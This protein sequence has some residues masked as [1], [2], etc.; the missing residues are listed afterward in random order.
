MTKATLISRTF[1]WGW[2]MGA[3]VQSIIIQAA[4]VLEKELGIPH[5]VPKANRRK[6][7]SKQVG[8]G[9]QRP[10]PQWHTS[11][12]KATPPNSATLKPSQTLTN[13]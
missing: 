3:E 6:L 10:P 5:L 7:S 8:E 2:L 1:N 12:N 9:S 13:S 4:M 11:S